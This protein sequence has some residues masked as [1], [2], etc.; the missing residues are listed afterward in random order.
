MAKSKS[1]AA[2]A[3]VATPKPEK[4]FTPEALI[5]SGRYAHV[6]KDF[7]RTLLKKPFYTILEADVLISG[8]LDE[9]E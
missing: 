6:Q 5:R 7:L 4:R 9:K 8:F 2:T 3:E 1:A